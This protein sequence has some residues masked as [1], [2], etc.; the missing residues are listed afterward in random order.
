[1]SLDRLAEFVLDPGIQPFAIYAIVFL[2]CVLESFF[3][4]WP[5]DVIAVYAGFL[6]GRGQLDRGVVLAVAIAGTQ[7]GVMATFWLARRWG[8]ALFLGRF[9]R[10]CRADRRL[11]QLEGWFAR[12]GVPAVAI[13]RFFPGIR[14]L[15][16]PAA[17][18]AR[19]SAS[20]VL[21][22][23]GLS[24]VA[25]NALVVGLG[26]VAGTHLDWAKQMLMGYN[27]VAFGV[28]VAGLVAGGLLFFY[29]ARARRSTSS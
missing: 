8:P 10:F 4:P 1:M 3:P 7:S 9:G 2:S 5:A 22:W 18:L 14:A 20:K 13:S 19:F 15:V 16:M 17:G 27:A 11:A 25:W 6:A 26:V 29:R 12:Y 21:C 23:A 28:V 24:V